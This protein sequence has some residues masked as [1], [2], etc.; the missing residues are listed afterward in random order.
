[1]KVP[2]RKGN[3]VVVRFNFAFY[4]KE[5]V[6]KVLKSRKVISKRDIGRYLIVELEGDEGEAWKLYDEA[7]QEVIS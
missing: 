5:V 3:R 6:E 7:L 4:P 1:M 2:L